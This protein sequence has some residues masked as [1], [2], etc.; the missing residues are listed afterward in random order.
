M[1]Q[2]DYILRIAQEFGRALAQVLYNR[3][4]KDYTTAHS[5]LD[6]QCKQ[7][8]GMGIGFMR[9]I[10]EV[11]LLSMLTSFDTLDTEKCWLLA[12]LLKAEGDI[13]EDQG[14]ASESY[15]SYIRSLNLFLEVLLLGT[16]SSGR[17][18]VPEIE[19][20]LSRL[21]D[22]DLPIRTKLLLF[23][24]FDHAH[25]YAR[26]EGLLF[27]MLEEGDS[28]GD[29]L[30]QGIGF[31][32]RLKRKNDVELKAGNFSREKVEEGLARLERMGS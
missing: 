16:I 8:F 25:E 15:Y 3:E 32:Q 12:I 2:R 21:S 30:D 11:T 7:I 9:S 26:A 31:F 1:S 19:D 18:I 24:Y 28:E 17:S 10:P 5:L 13:Y 23:R 29:I 14:N 20:L 22:Y 27:E 6:E 4:I